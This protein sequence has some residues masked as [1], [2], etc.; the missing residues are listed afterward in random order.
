MTFWSFSSPSAVISFQPVS[1]HAKHGTRCFRPFQ[2]DLLAHGNEDTG[3][4]TDRYR[5]EEAGALLIER[6]RERG[7]KKSKLWGRYH[8]GRQVTTVFTVQPSFHHRHSSVMKLYY[9]G[10]TCSHT[11]PRRSPTMVT[12]YVARFVE[13][14]WWNDGWTVKTV[15]TWR[16]SASMIPAPESSLLLAATPFVSLSPVVVAA[17]Y[18]R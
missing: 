12:L 2:S 7:K 8:R 14:R 3:C 5:G 1:T 18:G 10:R 4:C 6:G 17:L 11:S 15:V 9:R 13:Y 16:L